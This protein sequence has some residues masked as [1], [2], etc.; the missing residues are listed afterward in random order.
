MKE[1]LRKYPGTSRMR[2]MKYHLSTYWFILV[3]VF[4]SW[5]L[6]DAR[7]NMVVSRMSVGDKFTNPSHLDKRKH[8]L[9]M[10]ALCVDDLSDSCNECKCQ[11]GNETY[12]S[13]EKRCVS[14]E[15]LDYN[16]G[17]LYKVLQNPRKGIVDV[18]LATLGLSKKNQ[19]Y[20]RAPIRMPNAFPIK[21]GIDSS[22]SY[23]N[24]QGKWIALPN[25]SDVLK[26]DVKKDRSASVK[27]YLNLNVRFF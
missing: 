9:K 10:N 26:I 19:K 17:C 24:L 23:L 4:V 3:S 14:S 18:Q 1:Y 15:Q 27:R 21:C 16:T 13:D 12:L 7:S 8:C 11:T 22:S 20:I 2:T 5:T 25:I 6:V